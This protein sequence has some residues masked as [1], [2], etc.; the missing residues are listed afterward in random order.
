MPEAGSH[1]LRSEAW[2]WC[3][4][5][6]QQL[7]HELRVVFKVQAARVEKR[8]CST[9]QASNV[10]SEASRPD[11]ELRSTD[12][13]HLFALLRISSSTTS[14]LIWRKLS[15]LAIGMLPKPSK[16]TLHC[17]LHSPA[18][19]KVFRHSR[20][21][22]VDPHPVLPQAAAVLPLGADQ[23]HGGA[24]LQQECALQEQEC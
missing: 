23:P 7:Q 13:G 6:A 22:R 15:I 21:S 24:P 11:K 12:G 8:V 9:R 3:K 18:C 17:R 1:N 14:C 5:H 20:G 2:R 10:P 19:C 16:A 4:P